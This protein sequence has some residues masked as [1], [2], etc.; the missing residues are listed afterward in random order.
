VKALAFN[1]LFRVS[2]G[3]H[4]QGIISLTMSGSVGKI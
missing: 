3:R 4:C 1:D 2:L